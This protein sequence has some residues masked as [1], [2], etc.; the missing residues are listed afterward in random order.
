MNNDSLSEELSP[1]NHAQGRKTTI[2]NIVIDTNH[3][4]IVF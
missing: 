2:L 3:L 1:G 4:D